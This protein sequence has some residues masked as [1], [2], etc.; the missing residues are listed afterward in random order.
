[1]LQE[2][3]DRHASLASHQICNKSVGYP[4]LEK[5]NVMSLISKPNKRNFGEM[6]AIECTDTNI[7]S[8]ENSTHTN[9]II[10][11]HNNNNNDNITI[12]NN[13]NNNEQKEISTN[14]SNSITVIEAAKLTQKNAFFFSDKLNK[15]RIFCCEMP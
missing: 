12:P 6:Q 14:N 11:N 1:M 5:L 9:T 8:S 2:I 7:H 15:K 3:S 4:K 13:E 10:E